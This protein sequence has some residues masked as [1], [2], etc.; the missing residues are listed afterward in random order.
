MRAAGP[1]H[2]K[3]GASEFVAGL[4]A[5]SLRRWPLGPPLKYATTQLHGSMLDDRRRTSAF[6]SAIEAAV[7]PGDIVVDI[8]TG[9]GILAL[10]AA[11]AGAQRVYAIEVGEIARYA[12]VVF[13]ANGV[14]DRIVLIERWSDQVVLPEPCDVLIAELVGHDPVAERILSTT[15]RAIRWFLKPDARLIPSGMKLYCIPVTIPD[16]PKGSSVFTQR[17]LQSW[18]TWYGID[19]SP[20]ARATALDG[21]L[22]FVD[23]SDIQCWQRVGPPLLVES[24]DFRHLRGPSRGV[25]HRVELLE[26]GALDALAFYFELVDGSDVFLSTAPDVVDEANHWRS[27]VWML[28]APVMVQ[29]GD[30]LGLRFWREGPHREPRCQLVDGVHPACVAGCPA[31]ADVTKRA[32]TKD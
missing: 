27:P 19:F 3:P 9:T 14:D 16:T 22:D 2:P 25:A 6:I 15:R 4:R 10:V 29:K 20:L 32:A 30:S 28:R 26:D 5:R 23:T 1:N 31:P 21:Q 7:R 12:R 13:A 24:Y 18:S 17:R 11:R 8:G